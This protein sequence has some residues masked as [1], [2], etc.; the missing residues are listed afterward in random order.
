MQDGSGSSFNCCEDDDRLY[1]AQR[2][3][4]LSRMPWRQIRQGSRGG[5]G[6]EKIDRLSI[7]LAV[8][9]TVTE[10][11]QH[12]YALH[13]VGKKRFVGYKVGQVFYILWVDHNF[14]VYKH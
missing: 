12:F 9:T 8:P 3:F 5:F 10:D 13:Y 1:L 14:T 4:M 7:K 11:I 6:S 2:M